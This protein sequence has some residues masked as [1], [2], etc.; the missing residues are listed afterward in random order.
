MRIAIGQVMEESNTFVRQKADLAHFRGTQLL[1]DGDVL[2]L[3]GT[4]V[5]VG[6]FLDALERAGA[7]PV[8]TIAANCV[9]S[10][11]VPRETFDTL[12]TALLDRLVAAGRLDGVLLALHGAM[13]LEG[14]PD[15]EGA[16]LAA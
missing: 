9:S 8:P 10:G 3:R 7:E 5:E 15:G 16:L 14:E 11:P 6:G 1:F 12:L 13:V 2:R 4:R